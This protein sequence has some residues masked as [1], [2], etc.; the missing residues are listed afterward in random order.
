MAQWVSS[1]MMKK[2]ILSQENNQRRH[3]RLTFGSDT[4]TCIKNRCQRKSGGI[5]VGGLGSETIPACLWERP[6]FGQEVSTDRKASR[7]GLSAFWVVGPHTMPQ[8]QVARWVFPALVLSDC[9]R[10]IRAI[11]WG[12][13]RH[14]CALPSSLPIV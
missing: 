7:H 12:K 4:L 5:S 3:L 11:L 10:L 2:E 8:L 1:R 14:S 6:W 9:R 13:R